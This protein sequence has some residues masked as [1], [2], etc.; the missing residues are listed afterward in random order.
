MVK[1]LL[2]L[3]IIHVINFRGFHYPQKNFNNKLFPDYG[4]QH[5]QQIEFK[6]Y[7]KRRPHVRT[8]LTYPGTSLANKVIL[9]S[10]QTPLSIH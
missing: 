4:M 6:L 1:K 9:L 2:L 8:F 3:K 5:A 10:S 7:D